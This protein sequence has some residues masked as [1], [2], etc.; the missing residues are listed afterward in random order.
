MSELYRKW[1]RVVRFE[2]GTLV[3]V[4]EAGESVDD[5]KLFRSS[6]LSEAVP[7]PDID[8]EPVQSAARL[9][10]TVEGVE[11]I[12]VSEGVARNE[13][14][15]RVW[16]EHS[17]RIHVSLIGNRERAVMDLA[18]FDVAAVQRIG[19]ALSIAGP[20]RKCPRCLRLE[21]A[22]SAAILPQLVGTI[23]VEQRSGARDG[24]GHPILPLS[25][26]P[27]TNAFRP[28]YRTRPLLMPMML[29]A[30]PHGEIPP[31]LPAAIALLGPPGRTLRLLCTDG[32]DVFPVMADLSKPLAIGPPADYFPYA[33]G[34]FGAD[35]IFA[36]PSGR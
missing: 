12:V 3:F 30:L 9:L 23:A 5:G 1:G 6:P 10:A 11:R 29:Q 8:P 7:L 24:R 15:G 33:A 4:S 18:S 35:M 32:D 36:G 19:R 16:D 31:G 20:E 22:V 25:G 34:T 26:P 2:S 28:S 17:R 14:D 21:P 27:W 13:C